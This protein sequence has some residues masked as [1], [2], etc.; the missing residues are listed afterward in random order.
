MYLL[1]SAE[2]KQN[3]KHRSRKIERI[4]KPWIF[5]RQTTICCVFYLRL[6]LTVIQGVGRALVPVRN[7]NTSTDFPK[8]RKSPKRYQNLDHQVSNTLRKKRIFATE[9][10]INAAK[11]ENP[12]T[13]KAQLLLCCMRLLLRKLTKSQLPMK[14]SLRTL[15]QTYSAYST[16]V[17]YF[18]QKLQYT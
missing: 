13:F 4:W 14:R 8:T 12:N 16:A 9:N 17:I 15:L 11:T 18:H 5:V 3:S 2:R 1:Q 7:W 6:Y 10:Q